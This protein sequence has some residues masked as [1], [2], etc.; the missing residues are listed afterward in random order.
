MDAPATLL[1]DEPAKDTW[2]H[3]SL[4]WRVHTVD[5]ALHIA[6]TQRRHAAEARAR[7]PDPIR[8]YHQ[9]CVAAGAE[10]R[11]RNHDE[12]AA[13]CERHAARPKAQA[14]AAR[15]AATAPDGPEPLDA[16]CPRPAGS[17]GA[18]G[19]GKAP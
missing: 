8:N 7:I 16:A 15:R 3:Q 11:A 9:Q 4:S 10:Q 18:G 14:H 2:F 13:V 19:S 17:A 6:A 12:I 1:D 5:E